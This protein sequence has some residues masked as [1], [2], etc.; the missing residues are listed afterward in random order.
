MAKASSKDKSKKADPFKVR[1]TR[2]PAQQ[3]GDTLTPPAEVA[4]AIDDFRAAQEQ[5]KH[6]EGEATIHK[7]QVL[8]YAQ[9]EYTKRLQGGMNRSFKILGEES[10]V[11]Y[12]VMDSS[13]GITEDEKE[14]FAKQWGEDAAEDLLTRDLASIRFDAE[15]FEANYEAV[16]EA[17]QRLPEEV[18][19]RLFKPGL[20]KAVPGASEKAKKYAKTQGDLREI[21]R[22]LKMKN[23]IR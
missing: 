10:M 22:Q 7:D 8:E 12:V 16:V 4:K 23:Y 15:V 5:A 18:F 6:F 2:E 9:K 21:L 11:T 17:L 19:E 14:E 20:M 13:A 3:A 1:K